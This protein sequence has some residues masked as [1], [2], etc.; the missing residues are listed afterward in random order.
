MPTA[1]NGDDD[2]N[3][4]FSRSKA[5]EFEGQ[6]TKG[7]DW[8]RLTAVQK[9]RFRRRGTMD[10]WRTDDG[11]TPEAADK[12][13]RT[14]DGGQA[15]DKL[16]RRRANERQ[17]TAG[18]RT[19]NA[20]SAEHRRCPSNSASTSASASASAAATASAATPDPFGRPRAMSR[21]AGVTSGHSSV[22]VPI[23]VR[24]SPFGE[25]SS[26]E[27]TRPYGRQWG[28]GAQGGWG[29]S[30]T[31]NGNGKMQGYRPGNGFGQAQTSAQAQ[32]G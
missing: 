20:S 28:T 32:S 6:I 18:T 16:R 26:D 1:Y 30:T 4:A 2:G 12:R 13:R 27:R 25:S 14:D 7:T 8:D 17:T 24:A 5:M 9:L 22:F 15:T 29:A 10:G 21:A 19:S 31:A 23:S 3:G 11:W